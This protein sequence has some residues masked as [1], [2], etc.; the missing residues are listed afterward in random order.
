[1]TVATTSMLMAVDDEPTLALVVE[2]LS[3]CTATPSVA[4]MLN[5][6]LSK[7]HGVKAAKIAI[8]A[9]GITRDW[10]DAF[11]METHVA[12]HDRVLTAL[13][14]GAHFHRAIDKGETEFDRADHVF[15]VVGHVQELSRITYYRYH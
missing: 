9:A 8:D 7:T 11:Q 14:R 6:M 15:S 1:M 3:Y 13:M 12:A 2:L 5:R 10:E 4:M